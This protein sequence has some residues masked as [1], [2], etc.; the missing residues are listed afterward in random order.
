MRKLHIKNLCQSI[1]PQIACAFCSWKEKRKKEE[2]AVKNYW[3]ASLIY[4]LKLLCFQ[5]HIFFVFRWCHWEIW[6]TLL[7]TGFMAN[8]QLSKSFYLKISTACSFKMRIKSIPWVSRRLKGEESDS[9]ITV[10]VFFSV[11]CF[12]RNLKISWKV[13]VLI[14]GLSWQKTAMNFL[15]FF[16]KLFLF[17]SVLEKFS[18][19]FGQF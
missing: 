11:I 7:F 8:V 5:E 4:Y 13:S 2:G 12:S 18:E 19:Y 16:F 1:S 17:F 10:D 6:V 15:F 9:K 14:K 3:N